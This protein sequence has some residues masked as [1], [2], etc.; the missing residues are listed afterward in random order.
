VP[1]EFGEQ[2][3]EARHAIVKNGWTSHGAPRHEKTGD[4]EEDVDA[5]ASEL[6]RAQIERGVGR[7]RRRNTRKAKLWSTITA[8]AAM[9]RI[10]L[11]LLSLP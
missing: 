2:A 11:K 9:N 6:E 4:D 7:L 3:R 10:R 1:L 5:D 8:K